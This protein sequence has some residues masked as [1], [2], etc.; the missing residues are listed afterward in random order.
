KGEGNSLNYKYRMHDPRVGRFF[1]TDPLEAESSWNSPY[2]SSENRVNDAIELEGLESYLI[3]G[4]LSFSGETNYNPNGYFSN[5]YSNFARKRT[6]VKDVYLPSW[7]GALNYPARKKAGRDLANLIIS[8]NK[9][10]QGEFFYSPV[11]Y[12]PILIL[13]H[14]HGGNVAIEAANIYVNHYI[15]KLEQNESPSIPRIDLILIN[16]PVQEVFAVDEDSG[17]LVDYSTHRLSDIARKYVNFV[18]VDADLDLVSGTVSY[19]WKEFYDGAIQ[20]EYDDTSDGILAGMGNHTGNTTENAKKI[21]PKLEELYKT[22]E[23][24]QKILNSSNNDDTKKEP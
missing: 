7:S 19:Q 10:S 5:L 6:G 2:V 12:K 13:G 4:T 17:E 14:S 11:T 22:V 8:T 15:E 3:H 23:T 1:A 24:L 21:I 20:I 16:T 18:Q 9:F